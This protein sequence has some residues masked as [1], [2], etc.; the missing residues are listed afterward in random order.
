M[1]LDNVIRVDSLAPLTNK[2]S[3]DEKKEKEDIKSYVY[4]D[5]KE[6][7]Y[8]GIHGHNF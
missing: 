4:N 6:G 5:H 7:N 1:D 8:G 3:S 2:S